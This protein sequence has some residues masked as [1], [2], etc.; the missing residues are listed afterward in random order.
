L[1]EFCA[2]SG[3]APPILAFERLPGGWWAVAMEFIEHCIPITHLS[4]LPTH[5]DRWIAELHG[6]MDAFHKQDFVH[7]DLQDA[8]IICSGDSMMLI[9]FDWGGK[10]GEAV[11][12]TLNLNDELLLGRVSK[13]LKITKEDDRRVLGNTLARIK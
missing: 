7:G 12:P 4:L 10:D 6:L 5:C 8:N 2:Q 13:D 3:H 11:Y 9:D 1:H